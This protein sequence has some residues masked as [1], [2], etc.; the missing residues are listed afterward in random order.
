[1]RSISR[2]ICLLL[3]IGVVSVAPMQAT[4]ASTTLAFSY[5]I[6][7]SSVT[8]ADRPLRD[9][10]ATAQ[11][12]RNGS[13]QGMLRYQSSFP[14]DTGGGNSALLRFFA[15]GN[16]SS[17]NAVTLELAPAGRWH[18]ELGSA[19]GTTSV[20]VVLVAVR[21]D[22]TAS[23][24]LVKK[25]LVSWRRGSISSSGPA[26]SCGPTSCVLQGTL[27]TTRLTF[28][29]RWLGSPNFTTEVSLIVLVTSNDLASVKLD[30]NGRM[31]GRYI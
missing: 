10:S 7:S 23:S 9:G 30:F 6:A 26:V 12:L 5:T 11:A 3:A 21:S 2:R 8:G 25:T 4:N 27:A 28:D 19:S 20:T 14:G 29:R 13:Y 24:Q 17:A 1:M 31:S 16:R 18:V 15:S 22:A